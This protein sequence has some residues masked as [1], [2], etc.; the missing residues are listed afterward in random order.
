MGIENFFTS[1]KQNLILKSAISM[2]DIDFDSK[3]YANYIY[4]DFNSC[5]HDTI[6]LIEEELNYL[7][8]EIIITKIVDPDKTNNIC[9]KYSFDQNNFTLENFNQTFSN[10]TKIY[11]KLILNYVIDFINL[12][13][14]EFIQSIYISFD[15]I[16]TMAKI[17]EQK[18]RKYQRYIKDKQKEKLYESYSKDFDKNRVLFEQNK[19]SVYKCSDIDTGKIILSEDFKT[20]LYTICPNL[21]LYEVSL[22]VEN[23]EGE[24]KIISHINSHKKNGS[25]SIFSP[26]SDLIVLCMIQQNLFSKINSNTNFILIRH[27]KTIYEINRINEINLNIINYICGNNPNYDNFMIIRDITFLLT[28]FGNDFIPKIS[29]LN[30][31]NGLNTI[32]YSYHKYLLHHPSKNKFLLFDNKSFIKISYHN[33]S[34]FLYEIS[35]NEHKLIYETYCIKTYKN[36]S[37]LNMIFQ[38]QLFLYDSPYFVDKL[39]SYIKKFNQIIK[40]ILEK[41]ISIDIICNNIFNNKKF[42]KLFIQIEKPNNID[43]INLSDKDIISYIVIHIQEV[44]EKNGNYR[45]KLNLIPF[46]KTIFDKYHQMKLAER[47]IHPLMMITQFDTESYKFDSK[48]DNY[49]ESRSD[50]DYFYKIYSK[51]SFYTIIYNQNLN[52]KQKNSNDVIIEDRYLEGLFWVTNLY[53][54]SNINTSHTSIWIY[55]LNDSPTFTNLYLYFKTL[56]YGELN[57]RYF[58]ITNIKSINYVESKHFMTNYEHYIYIT[59]LNN[60]ICNKNLLQSDLEI[61]LSKPK[62][63]PNLDEELKK[64]NNMSYTEFKN[65]FS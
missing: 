24:A 60:L 11:E 14:N 32:L 35:L 1:I 46:S 47:L 38:E 3:L 27:Y 23:G 45:G 2:I 57:K 5:I 6:A 31:Q 21:S 15:G 55:N 29:S 44:V 18:K 52:L 58:Q 17:I 34:L 28:F 4:I 63:F 49:Y 9:L 50:N 42:S 25:Y 41:K 13:Q 40:Q 59:P 16:P 10:L 53:H 43:V 12:H 22:G 36:F 51:N 33:L 19:V 64:I 7:L 54:T 26:D 61:I 37:Y 62:Y 8:Y 65:L 48:L 56:S 39:Q 30:M 20:I